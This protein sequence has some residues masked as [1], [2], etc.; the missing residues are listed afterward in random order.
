MM[1]VLIGHMPIVLPNVLLHGYS[2]VSLFFVLSGYLAAVTFNRKYSATSHFVDI[3]RIEFTNRALRLFPLMLIWIMIYFLIGNLIVFYGGQYGDTHRWAN[4]IKAAFLLTYNYYLAGLDIGGLFG[5]YWSLF[6]EIHFFILF[7]F[8][9]GLVRDKKSRVVIS[10]GIVLLTV[11]FLRPMTPVK[12]IRYA[13]LA[14]LDSL[15]AG[16][17]LGLCCENREYLGKFAIPDIV[18]KSVGLI[19]CLLLF[20][21]GYVFDT[22]YNDPNVKYLVYTVLSVGIVFLARENDGWFGYKGVIGRILTWCGDISASVYVSHVV[23]Y[24]CVYY[25]VYYNTS[26]I[27]DVIKTTDLGVATQVIGLIAVACIV[28]WISYHLIE[29]PYGLLAKNILRKNK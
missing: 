14:H 28:G 15:F 13:T 9:F 18:K 2:F 27:P 5:Q 23:I 6:V 1:A 10:A 3:A 7:V 17:L 8:L 24:S 12:L 4:E 20:L 21:A 19:L 16:V 29:V 26:L 22:F 11:F 25:N